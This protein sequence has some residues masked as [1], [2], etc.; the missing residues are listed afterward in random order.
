MTLLVFAIATKRMVQ[1]T[2]ANIATM[3]ALLLKKCLSLLDNNLKLVIEFL[4]CRLNFD[5]PLTTDGT[6]HII[7]FP[8]SCQLY[9]L[10]YRMS[11]KCHRMFL[12]IVTNVNWRKTMES[13]RFCKFIDFFLQFSQWFCKQILLIIEKFPRR[14]F[15]V[16]TAK[17]C[18]KLKLT[19]VY[20]SHGILAPPKLTNSSSDFKPLTNLCISQK[21]DVLI[22]VPT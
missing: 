14:N 10:K 5:S 22:I 8:E 6:G 1:H 15:G 18:W 17:K 20:K 16:Q 2:A 21:K 7:I 13:G 19:F 9:S 3:Q 11:R 4:L 12:W